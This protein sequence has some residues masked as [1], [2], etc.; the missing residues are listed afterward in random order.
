MASQPMTDAR[1]DPTVRAA[2]VDDIPAIASMLA[3]AFD[4]DPF[5]NFLVKQDA[6][7]AKRLAAWASSAAST[8]VRLH[9]TYVTANRAGAALWIPP[10]EHT[11]AGRLATFRR[12][13]PFSGPVRAWQVLN[14]VDIIDRHTPSVRHYYLRIVGVE[15]QQQGQGIGT[16]LLRPVLERCD[17]EGIVAYLF[18]TKERNVSTYERS[19]FR[20]LQRID[21]RRGPSV[22]TMQREP[23]G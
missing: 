19:G 23:A 8:G 20:V 9:E 1:S 10:G 7:R 13:L 17:A 2:H 4:D 12:L 21:L 6:S 3:R 14:A 5:I 22:W 16:A 18:S 15:P 11:H